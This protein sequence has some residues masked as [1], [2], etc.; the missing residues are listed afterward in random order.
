VKDLRRLRGASLPGPRGVSAMIGATAST[1][2]GVEFGFRVGTIERGNGGADAASAE[3]LGH[4][5]RSSGQQSATTS[6]LN[7]LAQRRISVLASQKML[8]SRL[9]SSV[10]NALD[11]TS[12]VTCHGRCEASVFARSKSRCKVAWSRITTNTLGSMCIAAGA[13]TAALSSLRVI[14]ASGLRGVYVRP[15]R[16]LDIASKALRDCSRGIGILGYAYAGAPAPGGQ[17]RTTV[18]PAP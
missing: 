18:I 5:L 10:G 13:C 9:T 2:A 12:A 14:D 4:S 11:A 8:N 16:R 17:M 15:D 1:S 7:G 3:T 6:G